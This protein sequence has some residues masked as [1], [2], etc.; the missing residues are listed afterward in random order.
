MLSREMPSSMSVEVHCAQKFMMNLMPEPGILTTMEY[1]SM[2]MK[3][4][5]MKEVMPYMT[6]V[7]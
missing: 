6:V 5:V 7:M 4:L 1:Y 3:N 2:G